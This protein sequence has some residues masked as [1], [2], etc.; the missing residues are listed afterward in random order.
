MITEIKNQIKRCWSCNSPGM[1]GFCFTSKELKK[2]IS[3]SKRKISNY[4]QR[5]R[6][7][8][9]RKGENKGTRTT[10]MLE[11]KNRNTTKNFIKLIK[12]LGIAS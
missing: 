4:I 8:E 11:Q 12:V 2:G 9:Q 5:Y 10:K 6:E 3:V 1:I 7:K